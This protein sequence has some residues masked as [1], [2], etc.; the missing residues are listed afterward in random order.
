MPTL[1]FPASPA[2]NDQYSFNGRTWSWNGTG[3]QVVAPSAINNLP[4][5]NSVPS[6][7]VFTTL[8]AVGN[9]TGTYFLG[10]GALLTGVST[11]SSNINNGLSNLRIETA[12]ANIIA[13]VAGTANVMTIANT[14]VLV[15]TITVNTGN[16]TQAIFN[17][18][19]NG[20]GNIGNSS[21]YFNTVFAKA[22]SAQYADLAEMYESDKEY[23]SGTVLIFGGNAEVTIATV[24]D[25]PKVAGVVSTNPSYLMNMN[26]PGEFT[27]AVALTGKV[28]TKVVGPVNKGDMMVSAGDGRAKACSQP[29]IGTVLG[30]SLEAFDGQSG[31]INIVVG[32]L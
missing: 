21:S 29:K 23:E 17:G 4:I 12:N 22:T 15:T 2:L 8:S 16:S 13:N 19:G 25:D 28:P 24:E 32:R 1:N 7:G 6:T 9:V 20:V 11:T 14:G 18:G 27:A 3:W 26:C 5:G 10:N 31:I 30:K